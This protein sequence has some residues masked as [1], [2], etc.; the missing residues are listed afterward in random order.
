MNKIKQSGDG[1]EE[2]EPNKTSKKKK[3]FSED[4][5][6]HEEISRCDEEHQANI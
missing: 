5:E 6:E 3:K 2:Y 1:F 4:C